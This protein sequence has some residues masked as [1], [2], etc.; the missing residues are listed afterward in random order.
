MWS[1]AHSPIL[2]TVLAKWPNLCYPKRYSRTS[3]SRWDCYTLYNFYNFS[4]LSATYPILS[5]P[6]GIS[7]PVLL[8]FLNVLGAVTVFLLVVLNSGLYSWS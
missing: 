4:I 6:P 2:A 5:N 3:P 1:G 7:S 8:I